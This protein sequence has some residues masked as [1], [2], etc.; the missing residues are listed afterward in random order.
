MEI[1]STVAK[2]STCFR[3]NV[4]AII[5]VSNRIISMGYNGQ[6]PGA[7]H[8]SSVCSPGECNTIHAEVN[9]LQHMRGV[10]SSGYADLYVTDSPCMDCAIAIHKAGIRAIYYQTPYR[11]T[12]P[13]N[14]LHRRGH[15]VY[16]VTASGVVIPHHKD[17]AVKNGLHVPAV[18]L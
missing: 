5:V 8:C 3:L 11:D 10:P 16:R 7:E 18:G 17:R 1:A 12:A 13:I 15:D 9:A 2:R 4:G 14:V 6:E